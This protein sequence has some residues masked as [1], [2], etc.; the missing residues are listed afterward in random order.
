MIKAYEWLE[1][2][3]GVPISI[4][5]FTQ[6]DIASE[7]ITSAFAIVTAVASGLG[8]TYTKYKYE[9]YLKKKDKNN[10]KV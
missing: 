9:K 3:V 6:V 1:Y 5:A 4:I 8:I 2:I 10:E 7:V